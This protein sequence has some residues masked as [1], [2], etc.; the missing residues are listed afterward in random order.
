M[1]ENPIVSFV[2]PCY[3]L[4]DFLTEAVGSILAQSYTNLE[5]LI[6]D[7]Q[8][9]DNTET[10]S[11][12]LIST[13]PTVRISYIRNQ[14]NLGN[15]RNYN[16]GIMAA[17]GKYVWILSPDDRLRSRHVVR[18]YVSMMEANPRLGYVLCPAHLIQDDCDLGIF[19]ESVYP[20]QVV[21]QIMDSR[22]LIKDLVD[23]TFGP[24]APSVM[25]RKECYE[26]VT[27]FPE[28]MPHRGDTYVWS[29]IAM[30]YSIAYFSEA[31]VDYRIHDESMMSKLSR[32]NMKK[33]F[34]DDIAVPWRIKNLA[35]KQESTDIVNHCKTSI[36]SMYKVAII[37]GYQVRGNAYL[38][39][40]DDFKT[41][42]TKWE[43]SPV[44]RSRM[45]STLGRHLYWSGIAELG[46]GRMRNA[47][48]LLLFAFDLDSRL[49]FFPPLGYLIKTPHLCKRLRSYLG[50]ASSHLFR[51][52]NN[53]ESPRVWTLGRTT[54]PAT[55]AIAGTSSVEVGSARVAASSAVPCS[56]QVSSPSSTGEQIGQP[57][58]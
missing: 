23:H 11:K 42:L 9:P 44:S 48:R 5:I 1:I 40:A 49:R 13:N 29:M 19:H 45:R 31:M 56:N 4:A 18:Q 12:A 7:D 30:K 50:D 54:D 55:P 14:A 38:L 2:V 6:L 51:V 41:S 22:Q 37:I 15:I 8:S 32:E 58:I 57:P 47:R 28:D 26:V 39:S 25:V 36:L 46:R 3:C 20:R 24:V 27:L 17:Q 34:E 10:V 43:P 21:D 53:R 52:Y 35:E 16:K 33:V